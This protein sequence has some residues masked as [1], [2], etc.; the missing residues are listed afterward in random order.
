VDIN[1]L[2]HPLA[3]KSGASDIVIVPDRIADGSFN[4]LPESE[5][6]LSI[7]FDPYSS[8]A[9]AAGDAVQ[10]NPVFSAEVRAS[11]DAFSSSP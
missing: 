3:L 4:V 7:V 1:G 6:H 5:I 11:C 2:A 9:V 8:L 10:I